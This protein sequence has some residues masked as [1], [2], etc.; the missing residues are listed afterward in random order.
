MALDA[1]A[2]TPWHLAQWQGRCGLAIER[3]ADSPAAWVEFYHGGRCATD[4]SDIRILDENGALLPHTI[5]T[6]GPG[7]RLLITFRMPKSDRAWLYYGNRL[8]QANP[9]PWQPRAGLLM[10]VYRLGGGRSD[11]VEDLKALVKTSTEL[12]GSG[13]RPKVFDGFSPFSDS[14]NFLAVYDGWIRIDKPD[15]YSFCTNSDDSSFLYI[16]EKLVASFPGRHGPHAVRGQRNGAIE[17]E[18]GV[19]R[20][21]Y[22]HVE[23]V[24][25]QAAVAGWKPPGAKYY[26]LLDDHMF[27]P[28]SRARIVS[29]ETPSGPVL[30]FTFSYAAN[31]L[32]DKF[33]NVPI[34]GMSFEPTGLDRTGARSVRWRFGDE[35]TSTQRRPTHA[36]LSQGPRTVTLEVVDASNRTWRVAH[37]FPVYA[38]EGHNA[39]RPEAIGDRLARAL[40][41]YDLD[42]LA[43]DELVVLAKFWTARH[44]EANER[45]VLRRLLNRLPETDERLGHYGVRYVELLADAA[46]ADSVTQRKRALELL[47]DKKLPR[48]DELKLRLL[49]GDHLLHA[50][51]G[52]AKAEEQFQWVVSNAKHD[53]IHRTALI[54]LGDVA[55]EQG[56]IPLARER[57]RAVP[58]GRKHARTETVLHNAYGHLVE[59]LVRQ[60][61]YDDALATIEKWETA[62]PADKLDGYSFILRVRVATAQR[63]TRTAKRYASLIIEKLEASQH[64]PE[65]YYALIS[66]LVEQ[67]KTA[68]ARELYD[69]L[70]DEFPTSRYVAKLSGAFS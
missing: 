3:R 5:A 36:Y 39:R 37:Q 69:R 40:T 10:K 61:R 8:P 18:R 13:Y 54:R 41:G 35:Q 57:Y 50:A 27:V 4:G 67:R 70:T 58:L 56:D 49:Y 65:A 43:L 38:I 52:Y 55:L 45:R 21:T 25:G 17:L 28:I 19:H 2:A 15:T 63:D 7:D 59:N 48:P 53:K 9:Q 62:L 29:N 16:A 1:S 68:Q 22:F 47:L 60:R 31:Y 26:R 66:L 24:G 20:L 46:D 6:A 64:K 23:Y 42:A 34:I 33:G 14:D 51:R 44:Q 12:L 30:D 32:C 11:T